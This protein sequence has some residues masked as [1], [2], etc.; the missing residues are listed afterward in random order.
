MK[1]AVIGSRTPSEVSIKEVEKC[2]EYL[3]KK[4][5]EMTIV[6]GGA[7]GM[8]TVGMEWGASH[9]VAVT[10]YTPYG[11][12]NS[13]VCA[14]L[15]QEPRNKVVHTGLGFNERNTCI[16]DDCDMVLVGDY[17]NGTIDAIIKASN[18]K[19]K[20]YIFGKYIP[21]RYSKVLP[22]SEFIYF[23]HM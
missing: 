2:L 20:V 17:G 11:Y 5:P 22:K 3:V 8:D 14:E 7:F 16:I 13:N 18:R 6:T 15:E 9:E 10:V 1:I 4:H 23:T 12:H 19:K 21:G